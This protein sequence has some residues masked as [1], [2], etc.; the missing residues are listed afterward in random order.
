[1]VRYIGE[2]YNEDVTLDEWAEHFYRCYELKGYE[3]EAIEQIRQLLLAGGY[4][5]AAACAEHLSY[6]ARLSDKFAA[7]LVDERRIGKD[8]PPVEQAVR[9]IKFLY[10]ALSQ[11]KE[12][13]T[14]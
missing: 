1:M 9:D 12:H 5:D 14:K 8:N 6:L 10:H 7:I 2:D 11:R 3:R 4:T 13:L